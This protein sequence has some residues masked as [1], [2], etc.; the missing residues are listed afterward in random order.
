MERRELERTQTA[1]AET[2]ERIEANNLQ[3]RDIALRCLPK[4]RAFVRA[5][6][7]AQAGPVQQW[8]AALDE[9]GPKRRRLDDA[10]ALNNAS[11]DS[12]ASAVRTPAFGMSMRGDVSV[13]SSTGG[14]PRTPAFR[15]QLAK[16][17]ALINFAGGV[18]VDSFASM[19]E[20]ASTVA[21]AGARACVSVVGAAGGVAA[22]HA[23]AM[24]AERRF[25]WQSELG[26]SIAGSSM[27]LDASS[28]SEASFGV[29]PSALM[30]RPS[31]HG[32]SE[33]GDPAALDLSGASEIPFAPS[34]PLT[35]AQHHEEEELR[36][37]VAS[38][39]AASAARAPLRST[40]G[41][42]RRLRP[43]G[44]G[45]Q[46]ARRRRAARPRG[47]PERVPHGEERGAAL[48]D[49]QRA[50]SPRAG[51]GGGDHRDRAAA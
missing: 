7:A 19:D 16:T 9:A 15:T 51:A 48:L 35:A 28:M 32:R 42:A 6:V 29:P 43:R 26:S 24:A 50:A 41:A 14:T 10:S 4:V 22:D 40:G 33:G 13:A 8:K 21:S 38:A 27:A 34:P 5:T 1:I 20:T 2:L 25:S 45:E 18:V 49:L 23:A 39:A 44:R 47:V 17:P 12:T 11:L 30:R 37:A 46:A 31:H 3:A 36:S